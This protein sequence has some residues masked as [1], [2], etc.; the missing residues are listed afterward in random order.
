MWDLPRSGIEPMSPALAGKFLTTVPPEKSAKTLS[1]QALPV[2]FGHAAL[3]PL[4]LGYM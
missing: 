4:A 2:S 3:R 1:Q